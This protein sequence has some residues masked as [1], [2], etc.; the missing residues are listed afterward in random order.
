M[1]N[2]GRPHCP[3][4]GK[5]VIERGCGRL[6]GNLPSFFFNLEGFS[7]EAPPKNWEFK[8][9][10]F[11]RDAS[12]SSSHKKVCATYWFFPGDLRRSRWKKQGTNA[13]FR[14]EEK[15]LEIKQGLWCSLLLLKIGTETITRLQ[16][17]TAQFPLL[18]V[19]GV[20]GL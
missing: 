17:D 6:G 5:G 12:L 13:A 4:T 19:K 10:I 8:F 16:G 18:R 9:R 7:R 11:K 2:A 15:S 1:R 20:V 14:G 3:R